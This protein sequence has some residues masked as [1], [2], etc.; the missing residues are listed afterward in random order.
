M[1]ALV[2]AGYPLVALLQVVWLNA[3]AY[4]LNDASKP[5]PG[6]EYP[7]W[8]SF[9][10]DLLWGTLDVTSKVRAAAHRCPI[11][12]STYALRVPRSQGGLALYSAMRA[13]WA[14]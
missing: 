1:I 12:P 6:N 5:M 11:S 2:Q 10:K 13:S 7:P 9:W 4:K 8:L 3:F 14:I